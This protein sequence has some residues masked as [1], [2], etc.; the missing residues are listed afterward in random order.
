MSDKLDWKLVK[1]A[2]KSLGVRPRAL[3]KWRQRGRGVPPKWWLP[4]SQETRGGISLEALQ[5]F[6]KERVS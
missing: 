3:E 5:A 1:D 6:N 4:L 2:A